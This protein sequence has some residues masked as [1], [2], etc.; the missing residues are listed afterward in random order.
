MIV[1]ETTVHKRPNGT[2]IINYRSH[3]TDLN[4]EQSQLS[5]PEMTNL[6]Q[7]KQEN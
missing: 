4:I 7:F 1:M 2:E 6:K 5:R 3:K